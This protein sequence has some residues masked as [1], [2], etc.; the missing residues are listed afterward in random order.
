VIGMRSLRWWLRN[1]VFRVR[2]FSA[3]YPWLFY[4]IYRLSPTNRKLMVTRKTRITIEGYPR[5]ANTYAVYAFR[6]VN[7]IGWDQIGHHLHVQAQVYRSINYGI[8][9]ILLIRHPRDAVRSM[10]VRHDFIPLGDALKDYVR[11]YN[12]L[13]PLREHFVVAS[14]EDVTERFGKI[15]SRVNERFATTFTLFPDNDDELRKS[16]FSE[17]DQHN[18]SKDHGQLT[19]LYRPHEKKDR[20]KGEIMIAEDDPDYLRAVDIYKKYLNLP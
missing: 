16:V 18:R 4:S 3:R 10:L 8:P 11:F 13:Y 2:Q 5:S 19:H 20:L 7:D 14:F 1:S 15:I 6:Q 12:D 9:V 17:I